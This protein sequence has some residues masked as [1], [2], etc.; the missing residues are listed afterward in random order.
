[1]DRTLIA[2]ADEPYHL[3]RQAPEAIMQAAIDGYRDI[4]R[5]VSEARRAVRVCPCRA[6]ARQ[7]ARAELLMLDLFANSTRY[8]EPEEWRS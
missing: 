4:V 2:T 8:G 6:A 3:Y 5:T 1:M 7:Q